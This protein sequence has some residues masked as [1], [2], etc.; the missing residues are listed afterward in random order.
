MC[1]LH[2]RISIKNTYIQIWDGKK[3]TLGGSQMWWSD[4]NDTICN[5]GCGVIAMCDLECYLYRRNADRSMEKKEYM[6]YVERRFLGD[7]HFCEIPLI[8][9]L[10]LI[11]YSMCKGIRN[12]YKK[13]LGE[14]K[15]IKWAISRKAECVMYEIRTMLEHQIPV[16]ASYDCTL[17][18]NPL[19][20][21]RYNTV[22]QK[23]DAMGKI[24]SH[25][26]VVLGIVARTDMGMEQQYFEIA[27][28]GQL[29]YIQ[30]D[31]WLK[32]LSL[33]TNMLSVEDI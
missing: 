9:K 24:E 15:K 19:P 30:I 13:E 25:Y 3:S 10:G 11:P 29:F 27:T 33:F 28:Y 32:Q 7:Y 5:Y 26:F 16:V 1:M 12:Y 23:F 20:Y 6:E 2:E 4:I 22:T 21:Y 8:E 18:G 17:N 31:M 14:K